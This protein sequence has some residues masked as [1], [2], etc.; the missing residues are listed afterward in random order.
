MTANN[1]IGTIQ[2]IK[3]LAAIAKKHKILFHTDAVQAVGSIPVNVKD[4]NVD[5]L[6]FSAHKFYGPKGIGVL[7][8]R[9]GVRPERLICG[10]HQERTRRGGTTNVPGVVGMAKALE[11]AVKELDDNYK[12][13]KI[14]VIILSKE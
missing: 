4:L 9:N 5:M 8:I 11:I 1:E 6:S 3:E 10:G 12:H 7:Y 13:I 2:P 14:C